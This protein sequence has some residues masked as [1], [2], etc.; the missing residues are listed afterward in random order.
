MIQLFMLVARTL[1]DSSRDRQRSTLQ[2][3]KNQERQSIMSDAKDKK[4]GKP[5]SD[6]DLEK[7]A[8]GGRTISRSSSSYHSYH[9]SSTS[10]RSSRPPVPKA[11]Y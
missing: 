1:L 11:S 6:K 7:I 3:N 9:S 2:Q 10:S 8:G 4:T 5:L